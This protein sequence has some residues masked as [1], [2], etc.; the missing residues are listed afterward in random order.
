[1]SE[2]MLSIDTRKDTTDVY[3]KPD[4]SRESQ[5][6]IY[7]N[8]INGGFTMETLENVNPFWQ[9]DYARV[10]FSYFPPN[11]R[12]LGGEDVFLFGEFTN[13][14]TDSSGKLSFNPDRGCYE[15]TMVL[16]QGFYNYTY[17]T[18]PKNKPG[19]LDFSQTE[20]N[21]YGT[22]N[23]KEGNDIGEVGLVIGNK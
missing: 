8:D 11:N 6:Y 13:Y 10:H 15:K 21:Y 7:Y 2:R 12:A 23:M 22:K 4:G 5:V 17:V 19:V 3:V 9:G 14:A 20:G 18:R 1:M 16:K